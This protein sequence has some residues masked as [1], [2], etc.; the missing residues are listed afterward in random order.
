MRGCYS[1]PTSPAAGSHEKSRFAKRNVSTHVQ[2]KPAASGGRR[3]PL[4]NIGDRRKARPLP[5]VYDD[6]ARAADPASG[7]AD[8]RG[9]P[10]RVRRRGRAGGGRACPPPR[11][12]LESRHTPKGVGAIPLTTS[13]RDVTRAHPPRIRPPR[14]RS[15]APAR[16]HPEAGHV[17]HTRSLLRQPPR[18]KTATKSE[19]PRSCRDT[20]TSAPR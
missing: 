6:A 16:G 4:L 3:A 11:G 12:L 1:P 9:L 19:P 14:R 13:I 18:W 15:G 10:C 5:S 20:A 7:S 8:T 2:E 17:S